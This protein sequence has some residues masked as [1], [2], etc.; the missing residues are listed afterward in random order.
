MADAAV[1]GVPHEMYGEVP[2][3]FIIPKKGVRLNSDKIQEYVSSK[4]AKHKHLV[5][6]V[7][8]VDSIPKTATGKILRKSL[9]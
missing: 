7:V 6:G 5:G 2:K 1:T 4:V 8:I 9:K 3:A